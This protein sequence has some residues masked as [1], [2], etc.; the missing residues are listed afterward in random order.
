MAPKTSRLFVGLS[1]PPLLS[2][3]LGLLGGGIEGARWQAPEN[4]HLTLRFLGSVDG[5]LRSVLDDALRTVRAE[6]FSITIRGCGHF[7]P[8]GDPRSLWLGLEDSAPLARLHA[9]LETVLRTAGFEADPRGFIPHITVARLRRSPSKK[10]AAWLG[11]HALWDA[12]PFEVESFALYSSIL[13]PAG[14][15]YTAETM[16]PLAGATADD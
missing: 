1:L 15:K 2:Q 13:G 6:P 10:V 9:Q 14:S 7:P 5:G 3:Q 16:Y 4:L 11:M 8:R 12:P